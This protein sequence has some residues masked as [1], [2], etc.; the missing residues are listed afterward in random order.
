MDIP[1]EGP[2]LTDFPILTLIKDARKAGDK[3]TLNVNRYL[4]TRLQ[5]GK[6]YAEKALA[7]AQQG[8]DDR[9]SKS[10]TFSEAKFTRLH[11][12][13]TLPDP[14]T[15]VAHRYLTKKLHLRDFDR[16]HKDDTSEAAQMFRSQTQD[17]MREA[18]KLLPT[19][20]AERHALFSAVGSAHSAYIQTPEFREY[21]DILH[22][23]PRPRTRSTPADAPT[24]RAKAIRNRMVP[25]KI[26]PLAV[27]PVE[28]EPTP[29][30]VSEEALTNGLNDPT[31]PSEPP[32]SFVPRRSSVDMPAPVNKAINRFSTQPSSFDPAGFVPDLL[33][34][35]KLYTRRKK[36]NL[37]DVSNLDLLQEDAI[38]YFRHANAPF[39]IK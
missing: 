24:P 16:K 22:G 32:V 39:A 27:P 30:L 37:S 29:P 1:A 10:T 33:S 26:N 2:S 20:L 12:K 9:L 13:E 19:D 11:L 17:Q 31:Q 3:E 4:N 18:T 15:G 21:R 28:P 23:P 6:E 36:R 38:N 7:E 8:N 25:I 35:E 34:N 14:L 5:Y